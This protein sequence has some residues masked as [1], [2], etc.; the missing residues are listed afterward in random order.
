MYAGVAQLVE[1]LPCKQDVASSN[2]AASSIRFGMG[3]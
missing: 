1:H 2:L 3:D